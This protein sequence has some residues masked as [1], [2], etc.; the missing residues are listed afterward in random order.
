MPGIKWDDKVPSQSLA[1]MICVVEACQGCQHIQ[2]PPFLQR[3]LVSWNLNYVNK[4]RCRVGIQNF[5]MLLQGLDR[6]ER[7]VHGGDGKTEKSKKR[8]QKKA[9]LS[10][11]SRLTQRVVLYVQ[12]SPNLNGDHANLPSY[13]LA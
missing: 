10:S 5:K 3:P 6:L 12:R 11:S 2:A 9:R 1:V 7:Q 13:A 8:E 4:P